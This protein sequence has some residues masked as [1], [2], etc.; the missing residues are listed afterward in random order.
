M[1][2]Q[3]SHDESIHAITTKET[4]RA[5]RDSV[6]NWTDSQSHANAFN[7]Q[8]APAVSR[9][10]TLRWSLVA[11]AAAIVTVAPVYRHAI[12]RQQLI[13]AAS[14]ARLLEQVNLQLSRV[15]PGPMEPL[16]DLLPDE[17]SAKD[18]QTR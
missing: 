7:W 10:K 6:R 18:G 13:E 5:F 8:V 2:E 16:V 9:H 3:P 4:L 11:A 12:Q 15:I 17:I 14:D 1:N